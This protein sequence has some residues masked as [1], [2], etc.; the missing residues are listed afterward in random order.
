MQRCD[1]GV[2]FMSASGRTD[3]PK[4][5]RIHA[6]TNIT[7]AVSELSQASGQTYCSQQ[8][9]KNVAVLTKK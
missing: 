9:P 7:P 3:R 6:K 8:S 5:L 1:I 4:K 2:A